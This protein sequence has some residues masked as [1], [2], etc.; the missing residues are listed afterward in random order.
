M[1]FEVNYLYYDKVQDSFD[2]NKDESKVFKKVYGKAT[3]EYS[4]EKLAQAIMQQMARRD[5]FVYD[6]EIFEFQKRKI[7][8]RQNKSDLV[9]KN[10]KFTNKGVFVEDIE[11]Q[12]SVNDSNLKNNVIIATNPVLNKTAV[13]IAPSINKPVNLVNRISDRIIKKVQFLPGRITKP[14][15]RFTVEKV[16]PVYKETLNENGVGM[17]IEITDDAGKR[18]TVPDEHFVQTS[19]NLIGDSEAN[20]NNDV[21]NFADDSKLNWGGVIKDSVPSLR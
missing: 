7:S 1:G 20:F 17:M 13:N 8:F 21:A 16:Y 3:E 6:L 2:Y 10:K 12:D 4:L 19:Q 14:V 9:I 5:I 18:V 11:E 15:G